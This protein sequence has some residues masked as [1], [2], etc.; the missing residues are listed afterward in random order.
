IQ[1][2]L[3]LRAAY[4]DELL[5]R[6]GHGGS[7]TSVPPCTRCAQNGQHT[8]GEYRCKDCDG[9]G[10]LC[11]ACMVRDHRVQGL[12]RIEM[13]KTTGFFKRTSLCE[14]GLKLHLGHGGAKCPHAGR[15]KEQFTVGH[16]NGF[17]VV[18]LVFCACVTPDDAGVVPEW[19]QLMT[20]GW[21][22][23]SRH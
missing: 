6:N 2:W 19:A 15:H 3:P 13:W 1:E 21:Y 4:L 9:G 11:K 7:V 10:L 17:H 22:P 12:H 5:R 23:A 14:L 20:Y 16:V 18:D 8:V